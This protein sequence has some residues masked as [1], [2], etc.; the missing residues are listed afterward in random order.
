M[1]NPLTIKKACWVLTTA[2]MSH[3]ASAV[4]EEIEK[5]EDGMLVYVDSTSA[6]RSGDIAFIEHLVRWGEPQVEPGFSPYL[7]TIV[8]TSYDC[9]GKREKYLSS[10]S[11]GGPM[12][13]GVKVT[14]DDNAAEVW[15]SIS[16]ASMEEK[17]WKVA[18]NAK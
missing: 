9:I 6:H 10:I 13:N 1:K 7:S 4:W 14:F 12:G 16:D 5:F 3:S 11:Y 8:R 2:L 15:Y 17:L 18:C